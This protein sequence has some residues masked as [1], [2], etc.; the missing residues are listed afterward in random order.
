L[1]RSISLLSNFCLILRDLFLIY[2][3][4]G[5][6]NRTSACVWDLSFVA[7]YKHYF[8]NG[9]LIFS[10]G[11]KSRPRCEIL[12]TRCTHIMRVLFGVLCMSIHWRSPPPPP[13][14]LQTIKGTLNFLLK[15]VLS[16]VL[17]TLTKV[18][19]LLIT[20]TFTQVQI[21]SNLGTTG[22][23]KFRFSQNNVKI[24]KNFL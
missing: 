2:F 8:F 13:Y 23:D 10:W 21:Q 20:S 24:N 15:Y 3:S 11:L 17:L 18:V 4:F 12:Y 1:W 16:P 6:G 22:L 14:M 9:C 19:L 5:I 7:L